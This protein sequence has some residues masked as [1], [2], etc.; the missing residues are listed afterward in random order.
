MEPNLKK[1]I[2]D[3]AA[4]RS[5]IE[6]SSDAGLRAGVI[7][8]I[9]NMIIHVALLIFLVACIIYELLNDYQVSGLIVLTA[10][11]QESQLV[12]LS[13]LL[14]IFMLGI[15][16]VYFV[17]WVA[18]YH[19]KTSL[20]TYIL[21]NFNYL[22]GVSFVSDLIVKLLFLSLLILSKHPQWISPLIFIF[23]GDY[24]IQKR[25]F[26]IAT[27]ISIPL[28]AFCFTAAYFQFTQEYKE[29]V[30]PLGTI[31]VI[32]LVSILTQIYIRNKTL[33][34]NMDDS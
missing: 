3:L 15:I 24:L 28:A 29:V 2:D 26:I 31:I 27:R 9:P 22:R 8:F 6:S 23:I 11:S 19:S 14:S 1:A 5:I 16:T 32:T 17:V 12:G 10:K 30:W 20:K 34:E 4:L 25:F 7:G 33:N 18:A 21:R 13:A